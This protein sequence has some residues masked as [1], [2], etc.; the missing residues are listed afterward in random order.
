ME[1]QM[2]T[3]R[4]ILYLV[5]LI[6]LLLSPFAPAAQAREPASPAPRVLQL[7]DGYAGHLPLIVTNRAST[8]LLN[9]Y[10]LQYVLDTQSMVSAGELQADCDDLRITFDNGSLESE[11]DRI[12]EG[13]NTAATLISF[14][15]REIIPIG[16]SDLRYHLYYNNPAAGAPPANPANVY[17]FYDD[18]Q[19]GDASNWET[20]EGT[21]GVVDDGGNY[22]YRYSGGGTNWVLASTPV[23]NVSNLE[24]F[25][26][27]RAAANTNWIGLA[28]RIQDPDN[29]L[30]FYESKDVGLFKYGRIVSDNHTIPAQSAF[31]MLA[32]TWYSIRLQANGSLLRGRMWVSSDPEPDTWLV[33]TTDTTYLTNR[34]IGATLY[35]HVTNAD[36]DNFQVRMLVDVEP[37]V[38]VYTPPEPITEWFYRTPV[39]VTNTSASA[40]LPVLY[41]VDFTLDTAE[42]IAS[43]KMLATCEDLQIA[44]VPDTDMVEIDRVVENCNTTATRV[45]FALQRPV[46]PGASDS[47]YYILYGDLT[48]TPPLADGMHVFLYFE[49]W[50]QGTTHWTSAGGLDPANSGTMGLTV[51]SDEEAVSPA[52]S[53]K[54]PVKTSG[55][56]AFSGYIQVQPNTSYAIATWAKSADN[57]SAPVGFDPYTA[58]YVKGTETWLWLD[59][60]IGPQWTWRSAQFTTGA[61]TAFIKIKSEWWAEA[62]GAQ[63]VYMDNLGLRYAIAEAPGLAL[64]D[65]ETTL[66]VPAITNIVNNGPVNLGS[67]I[68]ISADISTA[69]GEVDYALIRLVSP[70]SL[71]IPMSLIS[72]TATDGVWQSS[73]LPTQGGEFSFR[74]LAHATT[75]RQ[76]LSPLQTFMVLD[77]E[78]P[79]ISNLSFTDPILVRETQTVSV[80]V[81]D[82]GAVAAVTLMVNGDTYPMTLSGGVYSYAWEVDTIGEIPFTVTATDSAGNPAV[83]ADSF[84]SQARTVDI[85]TWKGC[86]AG[87]ESFSIDDSNQSCKANLETAGFRGTYYVNGES[88]A[89]WFT[90]YS[91]DGHEIASHTVTHPCNTPCCFPTCTPESLM[92]CT[93]TPEQVT[94]YRLNELEPNI[95]AIEAGTNQPTLSMAWPCGC[96]DPGRMEA[97]SAYFLGARGYYD[98]V[99]QLYWLQDV[100]LPVPVNFYNLNSGNAYSQ[101]LIDRAAAEGKWAI[102]TSHGDCT[103]IDYMGARQDVLWA[104]PVGEVLEYIFIRQ[105]AE[106]TNYSRLAR[107]IS[108]DAVHTL[109]VFERTKLDGTAFLPM[110]FSSSVSLKVHIL[111]T[112]TVLSVEVAGVEVPYEIKTL[113]GATYVVF[114]AALDASRHV[115]VNLGAPLPTIVSV[116]DNSPVELGEDAEVTAVVTIPEG[117][118]ESV[119]L[120]VLSPIIADFPMLPVDGALDSYAA[121]FTPGNL[122]DYTYQVVATNDA[123]RSA[124]STIYTLTVV[125]TTPP[126][127]RDQAQSAD[128]ILAGESNT[129]SAEG[130]DIGGLEWA[131]LET[132][133]TGV[134]QEFTWPVSDWWDHS[135]TKRVPVTLTETAGLARDA[136]T[137][138]VLVSAAE[139]PGLTSCSAELR[140]ADAD[141]NELPSQVYGETGSGDTLSCRLLFQASLGANA[142]RTYF[143]Y[144]NNPAATPPSYTT[145]LTSTTGIGII[146]LQNSFFDLDLD[147]EGGVISRLSL[148]QG[149]DTDLPLS[150]ESNSYWGWHQICSSLHGNISGKNSLCV[151]GTAPATGLSL[152]TTLDGPIVREYTLTSLK[153]DTTYTITYRF[154]ANSAHYQYRLTQA[155]VAAGVMNNFWYINGNFPRLGFGTGGTPATTYN[156]Y[157]Y[158]TDQARI[159]SFTTVNVNAIDGLDNDGTDLGGTDYNHPTAPGLELW[160][161]TGDSQPETE[162]ELGR[163]A[164]PAGA[165]LGSVQEAPET[166]YG[167]PLYL[168]GATVW[169]PATFLW[170]NPAIPVGTDVSWRIKFCDLS[171]NCGATA[172]MTFSIVPPN[173]APIANPLA[174]TTAEDT[175]VDITLTGSDTEDDP[176]SFAV[177]DAPTHGVLSGTTPDLTYTPDADYHGPDS[178]TFTVRDAEFTSLPA[179]VSI[180]VNAVNDAPVADDQAVTTAEDTPVVITLSGSDIDGDPLTTYAIAD[181]PTHGVLSG[182]VP[183]LTYTPDTDYHGPDSFTFTVSDG[184]L[185]SA[186]ATVSITINPVNDAPSVMDDAYETQ[187]GVQL[188]IGDQAQGVLANDTDIDGDALSAVL[189]SGPS[190]GLLTLN[191]AG[192]FVYSPA[193]GFIGVDSFTYRASD[194]ELA[195]DPATVTIT[196]TPVNYA[197]VAVDDHYEVDEDRVLTI[198]AATGV[199][200]NDT[201]SDDDVLTASLVDGPEHGTLSLNPSGA[202]VYTPAADFNGQDSFTYRAYDGQAYS[203]P[204]NVTITI[205]E[206]SENLYLP[207]LVR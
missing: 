132:N 101:A 166:Q 87:A 46:L 7:L 19:D 143:I 36:W 81:T 195:S 150:I 95:A 2:K 22:V 131:T 75:S 60:W 33:Q 137:I 74:I 4:L 103:G 76:S 169:T 158:T 117:V 178:F 99:A 138:D 136:E 37:L 186:P 108:F 120:Q 114:D 97:A 200:S 172:E 160:V 179:T 28:F 168:G 83:L 29:F 203:A 100:N 82:N 48:P 65:E 154:F 116:T 41:T 20:L 55:G 52:N 112:D 194:G 9:R 34:D 54:F 18:F 161:T 188:V 10:T 70:V 206:V 123:G 86:K 25:S 189:E 68:T 63:P 133:E 5:P 30:T 173:T 66:S 27:V 15:N 12:V 151:G 89:S 156:L 113:E 61:T 204:A 128:R 174:M 47:G 73:Y 196:V 198:L 192:T 79:V 35:Q 134:W 201:D 164:A 184:V 16:A 157:N 152:A 78:L 110:T 88:T 180:T 43:G 149:S 139:F 40:T 26:Q 38:E 126:A 31:S 111:D 11:L 45:W 199:L 182:T 62:T 92:E 3:K 84:T 8:A 24:M 140:V 145:D 85:C 59:Y 90:T 1:N 146:T 21:W 162:V 121:S 71:D 181:T 39:T 13:C 109:G 193:A 197:P 187:T 148:P 175:P 127:W 56:D 17:T 64:G 185:T 102:I 153:S 155:G 44:S 49:D 118:I 93:Y 77:N 51:I 163:L 106:L 124:Q 58:A 6:S 183:D 130:L 125:D 53:Q 94:A 144:F 142:S 14:R 141:R 176:L 191:A 23:S 129:L 170:Q 135:W 147:V 69:E 91:A 190:H 67:N 207:L 57:T 105:N 107:T 122:G 165:A 159:A 205:H 98:W 50:E 80:Q 167:S 171:G 115:V 42:L 119:T 104:A 96:T 72:G 32:D 202:F 177:V